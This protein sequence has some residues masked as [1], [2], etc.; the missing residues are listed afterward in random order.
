MEKRKHSVVI[1]GGNGVV[2]MV[3]TTRAS[4]GQ[5]QPRGRGCF[6]SISNIFCQHLLR[7]RSAFRVVAMVAV[8]SGGNFLLKSWI[9]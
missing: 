4:H 3:V 6:H 7:N 2:F 9:G 5:A 8:E 1:F